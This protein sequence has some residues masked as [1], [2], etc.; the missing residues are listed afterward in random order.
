MILDDPS[1]INAWLAQPGP[2][3]LRRGKPK[4]SHDLDA[5][6]G[7]LTGAAIGAASLIWL[8]VIVRWLW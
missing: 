4:R 6:R 3:N 5:A 8:Y 7:V 2:I 1:T